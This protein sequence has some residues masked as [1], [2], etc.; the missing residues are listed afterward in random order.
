MEDE[1][2]TFN[3]EDFEKEW[4]DR[5]ED[6]DKELVDKI[7]P[8]DKEFAKGFYYALDCLDSSLIGVI[9]TCDTTSETLDK[10][11]TE[12]IESAGEDIKYWMLDKFDDL[13][14]NIIESKQ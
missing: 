12:L 6:C 14:T 3:I 5:L 1:K 9:D 2:L 8:E 4:K 10:I 11:R 13:V 7:T